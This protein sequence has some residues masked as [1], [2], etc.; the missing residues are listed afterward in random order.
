MDVSLRFSVRHAGL[1][2]PG[3]L[4]SRHRLQPWR[5]GHRTVGST[6]ELLEAVYIRIPGPT[7][8]G[9]ASWTAEKR[10]GM[11]VPGES[12]G[13]QTMAPWRVWERNSSLLVHCLSETGVT[14]WMGG[15][16]NL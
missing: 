9:T 6:V 11:V 13:R 5:R 2:R 14:F 15:I 7:L 16:V 4:G 12:M 10:P 8:H 3:P 1:S